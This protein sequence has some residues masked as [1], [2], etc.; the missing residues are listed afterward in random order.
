MIR[1]QVPTLNYI[2]GGNYPSAKAPSHQLHLPLAG[3]PGKCK[4]V[5]GCHKDEGVFI[6]GSLLT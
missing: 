4:T 2:A 3:L 5:I 6:F 1:R